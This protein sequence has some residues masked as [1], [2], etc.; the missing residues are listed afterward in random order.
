MQ[1]LLLILLPVLTFAGCTNTP[2]QQTEQEATVEL[3]QLEREWLN[4]YDNDDVEAMDRI[5]ANDFTITFPGGQVDTKADIMAGLSPD[6]DEEEDEN[7]GNGRSHYTEDRAIRIYGNTAILTG[8]YVDPGDEG[9]PDE[10]YRYTDT[11]MRRHGEWQVVASH[12]SRIDGE[13]P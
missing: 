10:R 2:H 8:V 7:E 5:V 11:W 13:V 3:A 4:A 1:R 9:E 12:L 6:E